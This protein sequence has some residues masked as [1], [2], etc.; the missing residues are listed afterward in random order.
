M[1]EDVIPVVFDDG[2]VVYLPG[3]TVVTH[4]HGKGTTRRGNTTLSAVGRDL[5]TGKRVRVVGDG[6][7][8][9][10]AQARI[11][12]WQD[13]ALRL[14]AQVVDTCP[15]DAAVAPVTVR[16]VPEGVSGLQWEEHHGETFRG[17][18]HDFRL[19]PKN[20]GRVDGF[21]ALTYAGPAI[22]GSFVLQVREGDRWAEEVV[23]L[24]ELRRVA[25]V[26]ER[27]Q[28]RAAD[29]APAVIGPGSTVWGAH[30]LELGVLRMFVHDHGRDVEL[31]P[32]MGCPPD[33]VDAVLVSLRQLG[34]RPVVR[35][36]SSSAPDE[37]DGAGSKRRTGC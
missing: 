30:T 32:P 24:D 19:S 7:L 29:I 5:R 31:R 21:V 17:V 9:G 26:A 23:S 35:T 16:R 28:A 18:R 12:G 14:R 27:I 11:E 33:R 10:D 20:R 37:G 1:V 3:T 34:A 13:E 15:R 36:S 22:P 8:A 4:A 2:S 6:D 25:V